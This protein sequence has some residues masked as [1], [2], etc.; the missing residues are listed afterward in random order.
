MANK[1][2]QEEVTT[3]MIN[4]GDNERSEMKRVRYLKAACYSSYLAIY[5]G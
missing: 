1:I 4:D 3:E 2:Q 5:G